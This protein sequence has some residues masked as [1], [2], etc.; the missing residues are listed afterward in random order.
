[1]GT[2]LPNIFALLTSQEKVESE[3]DIAQQI[4]KCS[5]LLEYKNNKIHAIDSS[6]KLVEEFSNIPSAV[7]VHLSTV[8][9]TITKLFDSLPINVKKFGNKEI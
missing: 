6:Q 4:Q 2:K 8:L 9:P 7:S 3:N 5:E 1:M